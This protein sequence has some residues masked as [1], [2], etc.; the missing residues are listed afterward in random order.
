MAY[1]SQE[2]KAKLAVEI[3]KVMPENWKWSLAVRHH[4]TLV[5]TIRQAP[6]DLIEENLVCASRPEPSS[7]RTLNVYHL[8]GEFS[9]KLLKIFESIKGAMMFGNHDNSDSQSDYFDV[10]WYID[11]NIGDND[12]PFRY[13]PKKS[14]KAGR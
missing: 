2:N 3:A 11:I 14:T 12:S 9:N 10:G 7:S 13:V 1:M 4:S 6:V 5:L 8:N